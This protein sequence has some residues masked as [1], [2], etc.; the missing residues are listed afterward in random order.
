VS[1]AISRCQSAPLFAADDA[2]LDIVQQFALDR[3]MCIDGDSE[4]GHWIE[5]VSHLDGGARMKSQFHQSMTP[6]S[7]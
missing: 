3:Q 1:K 5:E 6:E 7:Q 2:I 4:K